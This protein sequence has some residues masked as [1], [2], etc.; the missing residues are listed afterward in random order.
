MYINLPLYSFNAD[1][2]TGFLH[3]V[4]GMVDMLFKGSLNVKV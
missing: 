4:Q 1:L 3:A 2:A